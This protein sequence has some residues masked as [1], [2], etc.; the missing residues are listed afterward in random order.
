MTSDTGARKRVPDRAPRESDT[1]ENS[2]PCQEILDDPTSFGNRTS[3]PKDGSRQS[4]R[5]AGLACPRQTRAPM[6]LGLEALTVTAPP[7]DA[8][9][10]AQADPLT[11][12]SHG[13][14]LDK[15]HQE[16][17]TTSRRTS[18]RLRQPH[19]PVLLPPLGQQAGSSES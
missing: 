1:V 15:E 7:R 9:H 13:A 3:S 10:S 18:C 2:P 17:R 16:S 14:D 6:A 11:V 12:H 5:P 8:G 4:H 19:Q